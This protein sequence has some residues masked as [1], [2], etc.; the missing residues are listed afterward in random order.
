MTF[1]LT[2]F[3]NATH[4]ESQEPGGRFTMGFVDES[5]HEGDVEFT[6]V[7]SGQEGF[8]ILPM[9]SLTVN[10]QSM[11]LGGTAQSSYSAIDTG[12][13]LIGGPSSVV[14]EI[15]AA[16]PGS[17]PAS[18][19]Y[20]GYYTYPCGSTVNVS[21]SFGGGTSW[22][23]NPADFML[24]QITADECLGAFFAL[25]ATGG[26]SWIIGDTFLKN[27]YSVFQFNPPSVGFAPLSTAALQLAVSGN[28]PSQTIGS[29]PALATGDGGSSRFQQHLRL[30]TISA[31]LIGQLISFWLQV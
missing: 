28:L 29:N 10:G 12:T 17:K 24:V 30:Y 9:T 6:D 21:L 16:I 19:N 5:L 7:P 3:I 22:Q 15:F 25:D 1:Y 13:T 26:P 27:V 18:G 20:E 23:I 11:S 4:A 8:W 31:F 14:Q 2:R